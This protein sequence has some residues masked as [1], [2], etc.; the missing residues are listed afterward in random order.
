MRTKAAF[1]SFGG[2]TVQTRSFHQS[3]EALTEKHDARRDLRVTSPGK[4]KTKP[5]INHSPLPSSRRSISGLLKIPSS[6][7]SLSTKTLTSNM[8]SSSLK[9]RWR[10]DLSDNM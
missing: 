7:S 10:M 6:S 2:E 5:S 1:V 4:G 8:S 9:R 3:P